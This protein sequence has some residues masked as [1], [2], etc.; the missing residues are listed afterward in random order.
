MPNPT[1][2]EQW[3]HIVNWFKSHFRPLSWSK[4]EALKHLDPSLRPWYE[5]GKLILYRK[6]EEL[7]GIETKPG[8]HIIKLGY[9]GGGWYYAFKGTVSEF[10]ELSKD[11]FLTGLRTVER[12][13]LQSKAYR[14]LKELA[15]PTARTILEALTTTIVSVANLAATTIM[16]VVGQYIIEIT[17]TIFFRATD[18]WAPFVAGYMTQ[19]TG[20]EISEEEVTK[21]AHMQPGRAFMTYIGDTFLK[22]MLGLMLPKPPLTPDKAWEAASRF[23]G[24]NLEFQ[25]SAWIL[26]VIGD[27]F[28]IGRIK[29]LKDLPNAINW[30]YGIGWLSWLILGEPFRITIGDPIR[31]DLNSTYT[32]EIPTPSQLLKLFHQDLISPEDLKNLMAQHGYSPEWTAKLAQSTSQPLDKSDLKSL[33]DLQILSEPE[34]DAELKLQ[35]YPKQKRQLLIWLYKNQT[36]LKLRQDIAKE[37]LKAYENG[38]LPESTTKAYLDA[39]GYNQTE[40]NLLIALYNLKKLNNSKPSD[41]LIKRAYKKGFISYTHAKSL[42]INRGYDPEWAHIYLES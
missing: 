21:I 15:E 38:L 2:E 1:P 31:R 36:L 11:Y 25:L 3:Q 41:S 40:Q 29:S 26:H 13:V 28:S 33:I 37:A 34:I 17:K 30:S 9:F 6:P 20:K 8:E 24:V 19:L 18:F 39:A 32:P 22:P 35:G 42:L 7:E 14:L 27:I 16:P 23:L 5:A 10:L 12:G 4:E